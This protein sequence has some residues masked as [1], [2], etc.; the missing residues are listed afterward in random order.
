MEGMGAPS[1]DPCQNRYADAKTLVMRIL[2]LIARI[3]LGLIFFVFGLNGFLQFMP[4][5]PP[6]SPEAGAFLGALAGTGYMFPAIKAVETISGL[7]LLA[8]RFVPLALTFLAPIIVNIV[9]FHGVLAPEGLL[10][11]VVTLVL[12]VFLAFSY[13]HHFAGVLAMNAQPAG[14]SAAAAAGQPAT[15]P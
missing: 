14:G 9:L 5:P 4:V 10:V 11:P 6:A 1:C 2:V 7:L 13:R 3:L 12:E 15:N 8:G